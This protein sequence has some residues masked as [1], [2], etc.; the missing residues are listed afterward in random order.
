MLHKAKN[1]KPLVEKEL[2][3]DNLITKFSHYLLWC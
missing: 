2:F 3:F 1:M